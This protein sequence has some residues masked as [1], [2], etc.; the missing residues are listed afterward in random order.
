M[1]VLEKSKVPSVKAVIM[2]FCCRFDKLSSALVC[3]LEIAISRCF[4]SVEHFLPISEISVDFL[5][6]TVNQRRLR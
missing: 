3:A 1:G 6:L 4:C 2:A 5:S